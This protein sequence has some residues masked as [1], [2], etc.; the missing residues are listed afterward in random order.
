MDDNV[1]AFAAFK[2]K[3]PK[4]SKKKKNAKKSK[5]VTQEESMDRRVSFAN[6]GSGSSDSDRGEVKISQ[7]SNPAQEIAK[8]VAKKIGDRKRRSVGGNGCAA[9]EEIENILDGDDVPLV[10]EVAQKQFWN[11]EHNGRN[12]KTLKKRD[13]DDSSPEEEEEEVQR[14]LMDSVLAMNEDNNRKRRS[15]H[16]SKANGGGKKAIVME[17]KA[18]VASSAASSSADISTDGDEDEDKESDFTKD[19]RQKFGLSKQQQ[20]QKGAKKSGKTK[21]RRNSTSVNG[22]APGGVW[23]K[24][25]SITIGR[26]CL[27]W[28]I[29]PV[30]VD[31]FFDK[32]WEKRPLHIKRGKPEYY[33]NV[34]STK[35]FDGILRGD[36]P[37][38]YGKNLNVTSYSDPTKSSEENGGGGDEE[39]GSETDAGRQTHDP[40]GRA[41]APVVWDFYNNGCSLRMLNPQT[42]HAPVWKLCATLQ[43]FFG[44]MVGANVY[45]TPPGTQGF[46]PHFDDVEV[47]ILQ[48]E[49][50]K[51]WR[52]YEPTSAQ[53][54]LPRFSSGNF[55]QEEIGLPA[56]D[57]VLEAGDMLYMPRGTIHQGNCLEDI[58]SLH[59]T[60][61]TYQLNSFGDLLEKI[62]PVALQTAM[63][64]GVEF[65][66]G[67]PIN[68][69]NHLGVA[70]SDSDTPMRVEFMERIQLLMGR[71]F[72]FAPV[73][74]AVDQM[75][76]RFMRDT[77][78]PYLTAEEAN[79][80]VENGGERW[81]SGHARVVNRVEID[82]KSE[83]R[84]IRAHCIRLV[85]EDDS[86]VRVYYNVDNTRE[87][88]E[89]EEQYL[90]IEADVAPAL[91]AL[92]TAYPN[93]VT[94]E[95]LP[96]AD[97][98]VRQQVVQDLWEKK[99]LLTRQVLEAA[100]DD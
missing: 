12:S 18:K 95:S 9:S 63:E 65:R 61:S 93:Y 53:G 89:V 35:A 76:K 58:H 30:G 23:S 27:E 84:L 75:G 49:G 6:G 42:F 16:V 69:L 88:R 94:V 46:A 28:M 98:M 56:L 100:Y 2:D 96:V 3:K 31:S 17:K 74:A 80:C 1:S 40:V 52:V 47:F 70:H 20:Q 38:I 78:P 21:Q 5:G 82:P 43:D 73:D 91:E 55:T 36:K 19:L 71:L 33:K 25:S 8:K 57:T 13:S 32:S 62:V 4:K 44:S 77:L 54:R 92:V 72:D 68:Y 60:I 34:F 99:L 66:Q 41:Y 50:K 85:T 10:E 64:E 39:E 26:E 86:S 51:R 81:H 14:S 97:L 48:L 83:I 7:K 90:E 87:F 11:S 24:D 37:V 15:K 67:L 79:R 59:I 29:A 22:N 45:L